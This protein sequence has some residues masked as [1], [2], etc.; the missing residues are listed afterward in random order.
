MG[1]IIAIGDIHGCV[2]T[3]HKLIFEEI[4]I[5]KSDLIYCIGDYIDRGPDSKGVIDI[6]LDL[7][8][9]GYRIRTLRGNH[10]QLMLDSL[11]GGEARLNWYIN[12]GN[13]TLKSFGATSFQDMKPEYKDFFNRTRYCFQHDRY[14]FVHAGLNFAPD[15][16]FEDKSSMLW[17]RNFAIDKH[18]LG[19][20]IIIH[21]HT[22]LPLQEIVNPQ[23]Q[24][25]YNIDG[26]CVYKDRALLGYL[27]AIN[28]TAEEW[29]AVKNC[30]T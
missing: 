12:G 19:E 25:I 6:I 29:I 5:R 22:P 14:I 30:E 10:E 27:V 8:K 21:G 7:R 2:K 13:A 24:N 15:D 26:G 11:R 20:R 17:I 4:R 1:R 18:K 28:L 16:P 9:K 3:F 23:R